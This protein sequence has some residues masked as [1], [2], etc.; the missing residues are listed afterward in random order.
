MSWKNRQNK[1]ESVLPLILAW[2]FIAIAAFVL[3]MAVLAAILWFV[4]WLPATFGWIGVLL[5]ACAVCYMFY[6]Y[7]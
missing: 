6:K 2:L 4:E 1:G 5:F 7:A 3:F